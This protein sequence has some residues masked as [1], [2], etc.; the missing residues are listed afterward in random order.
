MAPNYEMIALIRSLPDASYEVLETDLLVT[1]SLPLA[2]TARLEPGEWLVC[3]RNDEDPDQIIDLDVMDDEDFT[4]MYEPTRSSTEFSFKVPVTITSTPGE[5]EAE[6]SIK[7]RDIAVNPDLV[8]QAIVQ[9]LPVITDQPVIAAVL[10][11]LWA[12][13][14]ETTRGRLLA[15]MNT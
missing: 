13:A 10:E 11:E 8:H 3:Y 1:T 6:L 15:R 2:N 14:D 9:L 12:K 4:S 7:V 5:T